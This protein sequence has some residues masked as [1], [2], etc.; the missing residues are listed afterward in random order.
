MKITESR[1]SLLSFIEGSL[2]KENVTSTI[3]QLLLDNTGIL[4]IGLLGCGE[5]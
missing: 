3:V 2:K 4:G 1:S 5:A